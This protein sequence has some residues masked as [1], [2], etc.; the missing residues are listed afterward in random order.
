M[1]L[2]IIG[3]LGGQIGA[4]SKIAISRGA[5]VE[6]VAD[7]GAGL[8]ALRAGQGAD[9]IMVDVR[10]D[11]QRLV[12]SLKTERIHVPVV[13]CGTDNDTQAAV[14]AIKAGAKEYIPLPPNAEL[15]AAVLGAIAEESTAI[16]YRDPKMAALLRMADQVAPSD[17]SILITGASGTGKE[18]LARHLHNKSPR[19]DKRFVAIN[20]AAIPENLLES[21]LFGHEKGAFTGAVARRLGK[22]EEANGGT[23]LLDEISEMDARLQAK[24]LRAI[25]E[26]EIDR[27]GAN[28]PVKVDVRILATSN[29][30]MDAAVADGSFRQDLYF[31]LN[32][33][34]L[35]IPDLK[36]RPEDIKVLAEFFIEKYAASNDLPQRPLSPQ[37]LK[38]LQAH[39]WPGNVR[40][41]ENT[42]H[43]AVLLATGATIDGPAIL[44]G[45]SPSPQGPA[46]AHGDM[47]DAGHTAALV[48]R[49]V[50]DV[51]RD[52]ILDTLN[53]CLGNRTHAAN[54]LGIS[55]RT[56][57]N[58]LKLY[59]HE[60]FT[61]PMPGEGEASPA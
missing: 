8:D 47:G 52:L 45:S 16:V 41:L 26:R 6:N 32:V 9:L 51:E 56:L 2:L 34:N 15:I 22:F 60:G 30:D 1:R 10:Q 42:M 50:S 12:E 25:Q 23:L 54:I 31:R 43:R 17:A 28:K 7:V 44:L 21:E 58:K 35:R 55:I 5:R 3:T 53:H 27:I 40:E 18:M 46:G 61:V 4:A 37:A 19:K 48:G 24:L 14:R 36:D 13:A 20:C 29:R 59:D 57:R 33:V 49:T 11:I 38:S 39:A